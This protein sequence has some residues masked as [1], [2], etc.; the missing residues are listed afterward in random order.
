MTTRI[1]PLKYAPD[2]P[3]L[4]LIKPRGIVATENARHA[5]GVVSLKKSS[6]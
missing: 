4:G 5:Q 6:I 2:R 3:R 1:N